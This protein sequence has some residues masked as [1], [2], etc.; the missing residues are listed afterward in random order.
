MVNKIQ[1]GRVIDVAFAA[2]TLPGQVVLVGDV[3]GIAVSGGPTGTIGAVAFDG[4]Y[5]LPKATIGGSGIA[6]GT[7]VYWDNAAGKITATAGSLKVAG[8]VWA[9][10]QDADATVA[11]RLLG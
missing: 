5:A 8:Y 2:L 6:Q 9:T 3:V 10:A 4:V 11:V 1:D 7:K